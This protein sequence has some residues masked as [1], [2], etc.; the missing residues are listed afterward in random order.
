[1]PFLKNSL[2]AVF[3]ALALGTPLGYLMFHYSYSKEVETYETQGDKILKAYEDGVHKLANCTYLRRAYPKR[4]RYLV[5]Y[6]KKPVWFVRSTF[7]T[8]LC[9]SAQAD[10]RTINLY[11]NFFT[12]KGCAAWKE[13]IAHEVLHLVG[14]PNHKIG[15]DKR[16]IG[17]LNDVVYVI[18]DH[19][20]NTDFR[21][22]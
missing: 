20:F 10:I 5:K 22:R 19:C 18:I 16:V 12:H 15:K 1:M 3:M 9:A 13:M 7:E 2:A 17:K 8:K 11:R 14:F 4:H 6:V 21:K